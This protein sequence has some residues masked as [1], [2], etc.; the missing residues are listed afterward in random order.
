MFTGKR[1]KDS[2]HLD[3]YTKEKEIGEAPVKADDGGDPLYKFKKNVN[4]TP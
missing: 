4:L 2:E 1:P 3:L